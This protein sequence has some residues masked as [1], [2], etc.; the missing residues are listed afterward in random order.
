MGE[1]VI[2]IPK[3][4][5]KINIL[6]TKD[7]IEKETIRRTQFLSNILELK[8]KE[9][10]PAVQ[11]IDESKDSVE[12][13]IEPIKSVFTEIF[14]I[15][16]TNKPTQIEFFAPTE[17]TIDWEQLEAELQDAYDRGFRDG[18]DTAKAIDEREFQ[19]L[20]Q[21]NRIIDQM[22]DSFRL[23][24]SKQMELLKNHLVE[25]SITIAEQVIKYEVDKKSNF[26]LTQLQNVLSEVDRNLIYKLFI[27]P[28]DLKI[29]EESRSI[30]LSDPSVFENTKIIV[31]DTI[32]QGFCRLDTSIGEFDASLSAQLKNIKFHAKEEIKS[33]D[34][35]S[36][37][38]EIK[39]VHLTKIDEEK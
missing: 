24:Y 23:E 5:R 9:A 37:M 6:Q 26:F 38:E 21:M 22:V 32:E 1:I 36:Q 8:R 31:D 4:R 7:A 39:K 17:P 18:Q 33:V 28:L 27:N 30:L 15:S 2:K 20:R 16:N 19:K 13:N 34:V 10:E 11:E 25:L 29:F 14:S 35:E 12:E 3:N